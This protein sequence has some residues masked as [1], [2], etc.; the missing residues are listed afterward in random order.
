VHLEPVDLDDVTAAQT[1]GAEAVL[2][3]QRTYAAAHALR[4]LLRGLGVV[5]VVVGEQ[6]DA[7]L[8]RQLGDGI[9]V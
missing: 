7:H 8:T 5:E 4:E 1:L 9:E 2:R 3:V 6:Y